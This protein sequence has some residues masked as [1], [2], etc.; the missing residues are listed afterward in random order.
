M[1]PFSTLLLLLL[2]VV[3]FAQ[4]DNGY[5]DY[6]QWDEHS[7]LVDGDR[8][9][10]FSGEFHYQRLPNPEL[11]ADI[12]QR[13]KSNGLNTVSI[14]FFWSYHS[15]SP[16]VFDFSSPGK[17]IQRLLDEAKAAGLYVIARPGPYCNAETSAGGIALWGTDGSAGDLRTSDETYYEAWKPWI[18]AVGDILARNQVTEGGP[19][20]LVQVENELQ[21][22]VHEANNTLVLYME[23][24]KKELRDVGIVVPFTS[25][26]K[27][28]RS[29]SWSTDYMNVGGAVDIY[30]LDSYPGGLS[31]SNPNS[32]FTLVRTY[33]QWFQNYSFTQPSLLPEFRG[34]WFEP[35]GGYF[36]DD[37]ESERSPEYPDVFYKNNIAN[38]VTLFNMYM[39]FGGTNW[40]HS[41]APVVYT[42][43]DYSAPLRETREIQPKFQQTKLIALFTRASKD[44]LK[45]D[46]ES[47][48]TGNAAN[49]G[50]IYTWVLRNPDTFAGFYITQHNNSRSRDETW[51]DLSVDTS[52]GQLTVPNVSLD[53]RQSRIVVTDYNVGN[54]TLLYSSAEVLTYGVFDV[55]VLAFYLNAGQ[56]GEIAFKSGGSSSDFSTHGEATDFAAK[57]G[58]DSY[59]TFHYTQGSG[60]SVVK[61]A[62][63]PVLY[64]LD[65]ESAYTFF[66]P[67]TTTNPAVEPNEQIFVLGPYLVRNASISGET[68]LVTGDNANSTTI[69]VYTGDSSVSSVSWNGKELATNK[70][71]YGALVAEI[72]GAADREISLPILTD[73]KVADSLPELDPSY[74]DSRWIVANKTTTLNPVAPITLPVLY[75]SD[76]GYYSGILVYRGY[77]DGRNATSANVTVQGGAAAGWSAWVNGALVGGFEGN[78]TVLTSWDALDFGPATL[79]DSDNVLTVVTDYTGHDQDSQGPNGPENPRGILGARLVGSSFTQWKI[80]GNAGGNANIDPVRGP[81][82]EGGLLGERLGWHLPGF[83]DADWDAGSP[84]DGFAGAGIKWYRT[85][86]SLDIPDDL[87]VPIGIELSASTTVPARVQLFVNGYQY[88]KFVPHI[89]PQTRFPVPPGILNNRGENAVSLSVWAQSE[90]GA[91]VDATLFAYGKYVS[92]F[93][94]ARDWSE[95]QPGWTEDRLQYA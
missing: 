62:Q 91:A 15:A 45:T 52:L 36:Y 46:M 86:F 74:D 17:D 33:Y 87:D 76:Y 56:V 4:R 89:G 61:F 31:C 37:C 92:G 67:P 83:D 14:Y 75:G 26:E 11:W 93:G 42:S 29:Q 90:T 48:G 24:I 44:L 13:F 30:G 23:Q 8:L 49:T 1:S 25:N 35:W 50:D 66:A 79:R 65:R 3:S 21:E 47:N 22:L 59:Q 5:T 77:F 38:R 43:Y 32:G 40:G 72:P 94:Y 54:L 27:G 28:M 57:P 68:V 88:G 69:E 85:T 84:A 34:G 63:G 81:Q 10:I 20:L 95:L 71:E 18:R 60:I 39:T 80:Q 64:L 12:F 53:G 70:T 7:L 41:A 58:N 55:P 2:A 73:W 82:N 78:A 51:F 6:V 19:V 16:D 9:F